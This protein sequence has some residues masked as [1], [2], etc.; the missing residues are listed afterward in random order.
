M[1]RRSVRDVHEGDAGLR[2]AP[3]ADPAFDGDGTVL[4]RA[5]GEDV[6]HAQPLAWHA[7]NVTAQKKA[8]TEVAAQVKEPFPGRRRRTTQGEI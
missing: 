8:A 1:E 5:S 7:R 6:A 2:V 3:G 4:R